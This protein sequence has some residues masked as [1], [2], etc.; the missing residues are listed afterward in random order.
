LGLTLASALLVVPRLRDGAGQA[1]ESVAVLPLENVGGDP[2]TE[3]LSDGLADHVINSLLQVRSQQLKV[4]PFS[5]VSRY[6]GQ[7]VNALEL[8]RALNVQAIVTGTLRQQGDDLWI[9]VEVVDARK[10]NRLWGSAAR[11]ARRNSRLAGPDRP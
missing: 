10:D 5:S 1:F 9:G 7:K 8:G 6:R 11:A 3:Y 2:K 4:R